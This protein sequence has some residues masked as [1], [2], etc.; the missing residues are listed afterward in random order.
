M[1]LFFCADLDGSNVVLLI[2]NAGTDWTPD[3]AL[4]LM[5][6]KL[7]WTDFNGSTLRRANLDGTGIE[8]LPIPVTNPYKNAVDSCN[9]MLYWRE[10][11]GVARR[12]RFDGQHLQ[13]IIS[14]GVNYLAIQTPYDDATGFPKCIP[15]LSP[16][17]IVFL[18]SGLG[19]G[20][21]FILRRRGLGFVPPKVIQLLFVVILLCTHEAM[22]AQ[23]NELTAEYETQTATVAVNSG[24]VSAGGS[25]QNPVVIFSHNL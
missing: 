15:T 25:G 23:A 19:A 16:L 1:D 20:A 11:G 4:D 6:N 21:I 13:E 24:T 22:R 17:G 8:I 2:E 3:I 5:K 18:I 12:A 14:S 9:Q 7:Y 10:S